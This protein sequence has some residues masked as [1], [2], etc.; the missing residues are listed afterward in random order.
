MKSLITPTYLKKGDRIGIVS[1]ARKISAA[2]LA[3]AIEKIGSWGLEVVK[4]KH[5]HGSCDQFSGTDNERAAD[6]QHMMDDESISAIL[7]ARGGYGTMR[8][9]DKLNND[10]F[11]RSPKW[12]AGYSDV[13]ALHGYLNNVCGVESLHSTMPVNFLTNSEEALES[14]KTALFGGLKEHT[15]QTRSEDLTVEGR[16]TGGNLSMLYSMIG[17]PEAFPSEGNILFIEDLD[18]YLYHIDRMMLSLKRSGAF[19]GLK[20]LLVG[21]L[22]DMNDNSV[23]FGS[24]AEEIVSQHMDELGIPVIWDMPAGHMTDNRA[25]YLGRSVKIDVVKG[26]GSILF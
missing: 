8:L 13:T 2:E 17:T 9:L 19:E 16:L 20:A 22:T 5:L 1:T 12:V 26:E 24:S 18:E 23:P 7:C 4:G 25:L 3:P 10:K 14:L 15:F 6:L 11:L 21:G